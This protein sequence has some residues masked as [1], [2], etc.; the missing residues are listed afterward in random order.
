MK[1]LLVLFLIVCVL[2]VFLVAPRKRWKRLDI[3]PPLTAEE[4]TGERLYERFTE[5]EDYRR[6][7]YWPG[8]EGVQPGQS[9]HGDLHEVFI[10]PVLYEA[11][12][13]K[14]KTAPDGS[15][16]IKCNMNAQKEVVAFTV[17]VK[18]KG[19]NPEANDWF[20]AKIKKDGTVD[21]A[22]KVESC[23]E[24]HSLLKNNDYLI[25]YKLDRKP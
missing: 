2:S 22:G 9:P 20:W 4:I 19:Y 13:I 25:L 5:E 15:M 1:K 12:P 7:P 16:V 21:A 14:N 3:K 11:L 6:Y 17:M 24:C 23:I 8:H 18:V 10:H